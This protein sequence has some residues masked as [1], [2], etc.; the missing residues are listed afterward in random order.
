LKALAKERERRYQSA[1]ALRQDIASYLAGDP[2]EAKR[3][4]SLYVLRKSLR[5]HR[6]PIAVMF[7]FL[8]VAAGALYVGLRAGDRDVTAPLTTGPITSLAVL[9]LK[10]RSGDPDQDYFADGMTGELITALGRISALQKVISLTSVMQYKEQSKPIPQ[11][12]RELNVDGVIEGAVQQS[13][14]RVLVSAR[15]IHGPTDRQLWG[16]RYDRDMRDVLAMQG[17][18]A[19]SIAREI[20]IA[21]TPA[22]E[23]RLTTARRVNPE[24]Y[25]LYLQGQSHHYT[26]TEEGFKKAIESFEQ[27]VAADP[28]CA[29]AWAGLAEVYLWQGISGAEPQQEVYPRALAA[30]TEALGSDDTLGLAHATLGHVKFFVDWDWHG[31]EED[32]RRGLEL[33]PNNAHVHYLYSVYLI[34]ARRFEEGIAECKLALELDPFQHYY[35]ENLGWCYW[36][37]QR[38]DKAIAEYQKLVEKKPNERF[39][40]IALANN[41]AAKGMYDEALAECAK[42]GGCQGATAWVYAVTGKRQDALNEIARLKG[43]E[44]VSP[45]PIAVIYAGLGEREQAFQWLEKVYEDR[46]PM[47]PWLNISHKLD[48][49]RD[50][51]RFDDLLRRIGSKP[52]S[53]PVKEDGA[54][55]QSEDDQDERV[56]DNEESP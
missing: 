18:I 42:M 50:D 40:Y 23:L 46:S 14:D 45:W 55:T 20:K 11:I 1:D 21:V 39:Y 49:L 52:P 6:I 53:I 34:L 30:A 41:Y 51:P 2:I 44:P 4:S 10:N 15:L 32:L 56:P 8:A 27:A 3:D 37:A 12:V 29:H 7:G 9:P 19:R 48:P 26:W 33:S 16:N 17:D 38:H 31:S 22:E 13:R 36:M 28:M 47:A 43:I 54:A 24:A 35:H 25:R 5:R